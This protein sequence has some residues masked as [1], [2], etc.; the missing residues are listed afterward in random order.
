VSAT[1]WFVSTVNKTPPGP[2]GMGAGT[3]RF[4]LAAAESP[5]SPPPVPSGDNQGMLGDCPWHFAAGRA[6]RVLYTDGKAGLLQWSPASGA[7]T[8]Y[9]TTSCS[10]GGSH[11]AIGLLPQSALRTA[12]AAGTR[13][14]D[15]YGLS[16]IDPALVRSAP[17]FAA[18]EQF[19]V[20]PGRPNQETA[21]LKRTSPMTLDR[22]L[23][24]A[25]AAGAMVAVA[26]GRAGGGHLVL[27][28]VALALLLA[29]LT[30]LLVRRSQKG[31]RA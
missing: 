28:L 21:T 27:S 26:H 1:S 20:D 31:R 30:L 17:W 4:V 5:A 23:G 7:W 6:A 22:P 19:V 29:V 15:V 2:Q 11:H 9:D 14:L 18:G 12:A 13:T 16:S 8:A 10:A 25:H 24:F 3:G